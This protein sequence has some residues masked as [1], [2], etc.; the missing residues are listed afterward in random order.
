MFYVLTGPTCS[1]LEGLKF[2]LR[3]WLRLQSLFLHKNGLAQPGIFLFNF[4]FKGFLPF[5]MNSLPQALGNPHLVFFSF[6]FDLVVLQLFLFLN[7]VSDDMHVFFRLL[8]Q[9][10][11]SIDLPNL[12]LNLIG[13]TLLNLHSKNNTWLFW[14]WYSCLIW[15]IFLTWFLMTLAFLWLVSHF[16]LMILSFFS[17]VNLSNCFCLNSWMACWRRRVPW[18]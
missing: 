18:L 2:H 11:I 12:L 15:E 1:K 5:K 16:C 3:I 6:Y 4:D 9:I 7:E 10:L 8:P 17:R 14:L 13:K